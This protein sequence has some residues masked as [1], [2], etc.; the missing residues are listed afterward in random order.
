ME[1]LATAFRD[2][3]VPVIDNVKT[4]ASAAFV[5]VKLL[6]QLKDHFQLRPD[7]IERSQAQPLGRAALQLHERSYTYQ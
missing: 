4:D 5:F 2:K 6:D 1:A 3:G 7:L